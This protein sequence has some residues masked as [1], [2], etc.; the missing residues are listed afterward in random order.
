VLNLIEILFDKNSLCDELNMKK[1]QSTVITDPPL[2][3]P[4][5][6][7]VWLYW[8]NFICFMICTHPTKTDDL[9]NTKNDIGKTIF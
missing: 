4:F 7:G 1:T 2:S 9:V 6:Q 5:L 8:K 3:A